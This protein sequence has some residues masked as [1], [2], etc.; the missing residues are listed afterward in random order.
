MAQKE[1]VSN[2]IGHHLILEASTISPASRDTAAKKGSSFSSQCI[3]RALTVMW[4]FSRRPCGIWLPGPRTPGSLPRPAP[5]TVNLGPD[6]NGYRIRNWGT[7]RVTMDLAQSWLDALTRKAGVPQL[8]PPVASFSRQ[9]GTKPDTKPGM[10]M[11]MGM[12]WA[13]ISLGDACPLRASLAHYW[14]SGWD[15]ELR[16]LQVSDHR[17]ITR[18]RAGAEASNTIDP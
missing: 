4:I 1:S 15:T 18:A 8:Q 6:H 12:P 14:S 10:Q 13:K 17:A 16:P 11:V 7:R 9:P 3:G 2:D 5:S